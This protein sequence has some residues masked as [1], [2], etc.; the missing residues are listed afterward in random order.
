MRPQLVYMLLDTVLYIPHSSTF[1]L[2]PTTLIEKDAYLDATYHIWR[3]TRALIFDLAS[4]ANH[5]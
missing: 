1:E 5:L 2:H 3:A 4:G